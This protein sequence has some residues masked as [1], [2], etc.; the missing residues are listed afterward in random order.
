MII[1]GI[2]LFLL[3]FCIDIYLIIKWLLE[4][5]KFTPANLLPEEFI[6]HNN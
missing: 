2:I 1:I 4:K 5:R 6:K 3:I